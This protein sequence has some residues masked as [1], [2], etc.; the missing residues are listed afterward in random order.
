MVRVATQKPVACPEP[1][2]ISVIF[3]PMLTVF[4]AIENTHRAIN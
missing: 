3:T 4:F 2:R 1:E